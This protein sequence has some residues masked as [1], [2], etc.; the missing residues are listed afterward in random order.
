MNGRLVEG[1]IVVMDLDRFGEEVE[2]RG[3]SE[4]SPNIATGTLT[5]LV[6]S[7]ASKWS[8]VVLYGLDPWRGTEEAV[9]LFPGVEPQELEGDLVSI[10][11]AIEG[12]GYSISIVALRA[13]IVSYKPQRARRLD[14]P[15][16]KRAKRLLGM[17]KKRGGGMVLVED[18]IVYRSRR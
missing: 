8:A 18:R 15:Y 11:K 3:L 17:V 5:S 4:Y 9:L 10:A 14:N 6:E 16:Y 2:K 13:P 12:L 1:T 7:L